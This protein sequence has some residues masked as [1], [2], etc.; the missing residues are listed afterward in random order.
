MLVLLKAGAL[1]TGAFSPARYPY[2]GSPFETS[3]WHHQDSYQ[4][5][6]C[7]VKL[8]IQEERTLRMYSGTPQFKTA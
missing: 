1:S 8:E 6:A 4:K 7:L 2:P 5:S 3:S